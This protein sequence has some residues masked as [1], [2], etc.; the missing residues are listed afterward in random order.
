[1]VKNE[2]AAG[3]N[4]RHVSAAAWVARTNLSFHISPWNQASSH[5]P[6]MAARYAAARQWHRISVPSVDLAAFILQDLA[7]NIRGETSGAGAGADSESEPPLVFLKL[8]IEGAEYS[9][10][11]RLLLTRA[12]CTVSHLHVEWHLNSTPPSERLAALGLRHTL[13]H[14]LSRGCR[15]PP[16]AVAH[17]E[18]ASTNNEPIPGLR[19]EVEKRRNGSS[20]LAFHPVHKYK[21]QA[22]SAAHERVHNSTTDTE[23]H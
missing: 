15:M 21:Q 2:H 19:E 1:M 9:V 13:G 14:V 16:H 17:E 18:G 22:W 5:L 23:L 4:A 6:V 10:L 12:L 3:I 7:L 11:P 20:T 8:D